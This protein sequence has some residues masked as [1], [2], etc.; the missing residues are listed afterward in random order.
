MLHPVNYVTEE[1]WH[2]ADFFQV[3][4]LDGGGYFSFLSLVGAT[5]D[6]AVAEATRTGRIF[7][8]FRNR[9]GQVNWELHDRWDSIEAGVWLNR[10]YYLASTAR[11]YWLTGDEGFSEAVLNICRQ[12]V[13]SVPY[14][15]DY[16]AYFNTFR[17]G[18]DAGNRR[19]GARACSTWCDF[20]LA[21]RVLIAYW[22]P[23]FLAGS[24]RWTHTD[25]ARLEE[26]MLRHARLL[27][28]ADRDG[29][30]EPGNHQ[31]LRGYALMHAAAMLRTA[32][33]SEAWWELGV[34]LMS[35]H[36]EGDFTSGGVSR[37]GS[38]S[39]QLFMLSLFVHA[40]SLARAVNK[41]IPAEWGNVAKKMARFISLTATPALTTP[42]VNDGY[43]APIGPVLDIC[44]EQ[45]PELAEAVS[46][47][48]PQRLVLE[49]FPDAGVAVLDARS[50]PGRLW[51]LTECLTPYGHSGHWHAGKPTLHVWVNDRM[52][53]GDAGCPSYDDPLYGAWFRR[54]PA[55]F[56]VTVDGLEDAEFVS[57][58]RWDKPP[59]VKVTRCEQVE[60]GAVIEFESDGFRRLSSPL[61]YRRLVSYTRE[62]ELT[63]RDVLR[64][65]SGAAAHTFALHV[66]FLVQDV[67][68]SAPDRVIARVGDH[69]ASISWSVT[70][71]KAVAQLLRK[72]VCV[73]AR[74]GEYPYL[75]I[76]V[77]DVPET[78]FITRIALV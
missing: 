12:W 24:A 58:I 28:L 8:R 22:L 48:R 23:F 38:F 32:E 18:F 57:D 3:F 78:E 15:D 54:G 62:G 27:R 63:V 41:E 43:E 70:N 36:A 46:P 69:A 53:L 13:S 74:Q 77:S 56:A 20:Q 55:H 39:Y 35:L 42:V 66:P 51:L 71:G 33:E 73:G 37:E 30:F 50:G 44:R 11:M 40:M 16:A 1:L 76:E 26:L 45:F 65:Q 4:P 6:R 5:D 25:W 10:W 75:Q 49:S 67:Q 7:D 17:S 64:S 52:L 61:S 21:E 68:L 14:P 9:D 34:R 60:G 29:T 31:M 72:P 47:Q 19:T 59:A 2:R